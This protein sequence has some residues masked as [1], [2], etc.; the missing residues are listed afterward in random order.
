VRL[1]EAIDLA[2][3]QPLECLEDYASIKREIEMEIGPEP[4]LEIVITNDT[5]RID[6]HEIKLVTTIS[7][8]ELQNNRTKHNLKK[9]IRA[10]NVESKP[11][12][13]EGPPSTGKTAL[14]EL[15][16]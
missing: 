5:L 13:I 12:L 4:P 10:V 9:L 11:I 14:V 8:I 1:Y 15:L 2:I 7:T 6:P 3:L 16:A